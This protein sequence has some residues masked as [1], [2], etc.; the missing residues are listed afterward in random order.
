MPIK[1]P[2]VKHPIIT[3]AQSIHTN[4]P[5]T[6]VPCPLHSLYI[7][8]PLS[9]ACPVPDS[10]CG[11]WLPHIRASPLLV[12]ERDVDATFYLIITREPNSRVLNKLRV[13]LMGARQCAETSREPVCGK[14]P[15]YCY[16]ILHVTL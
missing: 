7:P 8:T 11:Q 3:P 13:R 10:G 14:S 1:C 9:P 4:S 15:R 12:Q 2:P 16:R 6:H 5:L